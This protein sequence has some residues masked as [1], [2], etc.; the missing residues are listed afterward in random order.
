MWRH[1]YKRLHQAHS[2]ASLALSSITSTPA[3]SLGSF[4]S[5][6]SLAAAAP[7]LPTYYA[8]RPA[9]P[10]YV[11]PT[12]DPAPSYAQKAATHPHTYLVPLSLVLLVTLA[13]IFGLLLL[14]QYEG[15]VD[16]SWLAWVSS[17]SSSAA[18]AASSSSTGSGGGVLNTGVNTGGGGGLGVSSSA[19]RSSSSSSSRAAGAVVPSSSSRASSSSSSSNAQAGVVPSS[20]GVV[21]TTSVVSPTPSG[22]VWNL[23]LDNSYLDSAVAGRATL[24]NTSDTV[25]CTPSFRAT[26]GPAS[27]Q[28]HAFFNPCS[29]TGNGLVLGYAGMTTSYTMEVWYSNSLSVATGALFIFGSCVS[30]L[31]G[32]VVHPNFNGGSYFDQTGQFPSCPT[33]SNVQTPGW[34]MYGVTYDDTTAIYN[35]YFNGVGVCEYRSSTYWDRLVS[36]TPCLAV[37]ASDQP[38]SDDT[39]LPGLFYNF[40]G[41]DYA[42]SDAQM[43]ADY[44]AAIH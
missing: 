25:A 5:Y 30:E 26:A 32:Y 18:A 36:P 11:E 2:R 1:N 33:S 29:T 28:V 7:P 44:S 37:G 14:L 6:F 15:A 4:G 10:T 35:T 22:V 27:R 9:A 24:A 17:S 20:S 40:T 42:R 13:T 23:L 38:I 39:P 43:A 16:F 34:N 12:P 31:G 3:P 41:W 21:S 8:P 19:P